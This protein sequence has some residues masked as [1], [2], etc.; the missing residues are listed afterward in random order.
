MLLLL[1]LSPQ[2]TASRCPAD[3][4]Q[5]VPTFRLLQCSLLPEVTMAMARLEPWLKSE[6]KMAA[7][8][9]LL[10]VACL[11]C[12]AS[13]LGVGWL[14]LMAKVAHIHF[15]IDI[16]WLCLE[17]PPS[18]STAGYQNLKVEMAGGKGRASARAVGELH[19]PVRGGVPIRKVHA[20]N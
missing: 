13:Y 18:E 17:C 7:F 6:Q 3:T 16:N 1:I 10:E 5:Q 2:A 20:K 19:V 9:C 12:L 11:P 8:L 4:G 14:L 15:T